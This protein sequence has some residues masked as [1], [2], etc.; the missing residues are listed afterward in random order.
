MPTVTDPPATNP[1]GPE[2]LLL[3]QVLKASYWAVAIRGFDK[4][5]RIARVA[6][7]ARILVPDDFGLFGISLLAL[8]LVEALSQTGFAAALIQRQD[9][10]APYLSTA[11]TLQVLRGFGLAEIL[12]AAAPFVAVF[13]EEPAAEPMIKVIAANAL[14]LGLTNI[15]VTRFL[16]E[17][18]YHRHFVYVFPAT[19]V[20]LAV[21]IWAALELRNAWALVF[22]LLAG[23]LVRVVTSH[24]MA[25]PVGFRMDRESARRL[26][27]FGRWIWGTHVA[28]FALN[29]GDDIF[30]LKLLGTESLG[31]Y[32]MAYLFGNLPATEITHIVS[33]VSFPA[34]AKLQGDPARVRDAFLRTLRVTLF[35]S[36]PFAFGI[37]VMSSG[38][39][40]IFLGTGAVNPWTPMILPMQI[41]ATWG[42]IRSSGATTGS[43]FHGTGRP[44]IVTK[45]AYLKL[46]VLATIIYPFTVTWGMAGTAAAV[47]AAALV[48]NPLASYAAIKVTGCRVR[49]FVAAI[50]FPILASAAMALVILG[51]HSVTG[52]EY[53]MPVFVLSVAVGVV[54]YGLAYLLLRS[55]FGYDIAL[56]FKSVAED[57]DK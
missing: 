44:E 6:V 21:S 37:V 19:L 7:L 23:S 16:K 17:L 4:A 53:G 9:D 57:K 1:A 46:A 3:K 26:V 34:Y 48:S 24:L 38:F 36:A 31:I 10:I 54:A 28:A 56:A 27:S 49:D 32:R 35:F 2:P 18:E 11:W 30:V 14:L 8:A 29:E 33:N 47:V 50:G 51:L 40:R 41:L 45:L 55:L 22:G 15:G 43:L 12:Y 39:V 42:L 5:V 13:V 20:D 52:P 25:P